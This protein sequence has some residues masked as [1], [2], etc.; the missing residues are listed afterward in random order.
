ME[1]D[2]QNEQKRVKRIS[3]N[4]KGYSRIICN[5]NAPSSRHHGLSLVVGGVHRGHRFISAHACQCSFS[6]CVDTGYYD[7]DHD[8]G[9]A[10]AD[11]D[12]NAAADQEHA[13]SGHDED[14]W[15][16]TD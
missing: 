9:E 5:G 11:C 6:D 16:E 4:G 10:D 2:D 1:N 13:K 8:G 7:S 12:D 15:K 3:T 14:S